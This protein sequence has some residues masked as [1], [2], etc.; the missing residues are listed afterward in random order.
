MKC[1]I[2]RLS[3]LRQLH[4]R[5]APFLPI[6]R[7]IR[8]CM[9]SS[10]RF[11][12]N[13]EVY[14]CSFP[15]FSAASGDESYQSSCTLRACLKCTF[16]SNS[17]FG[18]LNYLVRNLCVGPDCSEC[19]LCAYLQPRRFFIG[20]FS[21]NC[22]NT[23]VSRDVYLYFVCSICIRVRNTNFKSFHVIVLNDESHYRNA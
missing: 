19:T 22:P 2:V 13:P 4:F 15:N 17:M 1:T 21:N 23:L 14:Y 5:L 3:L 10:V 18:L 7:G 20:Q 12:G 16:A 6:L 11:Q 8:K 9:Y